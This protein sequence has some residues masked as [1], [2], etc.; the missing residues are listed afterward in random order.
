MRVG[1]KGSDLFK[2]GESAESVARGFRRGEQRV[3]ARRFVAMS[4]L[5]RL[6]AWGK[7]STVMLW[8]RNSSSVAVMDMRSILEAQRRVLWPTMQL[9][10]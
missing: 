1:F 3:E 10:P 4:T 7:S 5:V 6:M 9:A 8:E 2:N